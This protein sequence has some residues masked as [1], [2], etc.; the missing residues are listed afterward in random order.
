[1]SRCRY[2]S[3]PREV[4]NYNSF[5]LGQ[6]LLLNPLLILK[7]CFLIIKS[8]HYQPKGCYG[9]AIAKVL[10]R[11]GLHHTVFRLYL[12]GSIWVL[13]LK[14]FKCHF[15]LVP[16]WPDLCKIL[17]LL[18]PFWVFGKSF[19]FVLYSV[20]QIF[21]LLWQKTFCWDNFHCFK[22]PNTDQIV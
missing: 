8:T 7:C 22:W 17:L 1:M 13:L 10:S 5:P 2:D 6:I 12:E 14:C 21:K 18:L 20:W 4:R 11:G 16:V 15:Y 9:V 3:V 19:C